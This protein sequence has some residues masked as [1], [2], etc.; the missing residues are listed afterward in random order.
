MKKIRQST[1]KKLWD[2]ASIIYPDYKYEY[3]EEKQSWEVNIYFEADEKEA[4]KTW[5]RIQDSVCSADHHALEMCPGP[6]FTSG[7]R[8]VI[9]DKEKD[10]FIEINRKDIK[11]ES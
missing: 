5:E 8:P 1:A 7:M 10:K 4:E 9:F 6:F 2:L 3:L 11:N